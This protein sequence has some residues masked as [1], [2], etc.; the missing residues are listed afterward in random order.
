MRDVVAI[1]H[2]VEMDFRDARIR[3][4][5][6]ALYVARLGHDAK[7]AAT[8]RHEFAAVFFRA[9]M[10]DERAECLS[11]LDARALGSRPTP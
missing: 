3:F 10:D 11:V 6:G 1:V 2:A 9:R 5:D 7:H 4:V 8:I